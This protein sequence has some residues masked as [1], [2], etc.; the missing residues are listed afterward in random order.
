MNG[1]NNYWDSEGRIKPITIKT[2]AEDHGSYELPDKNIFNKRKVRGIAVRPPENRKRLTENG[3]NLVNEDVFYASFLSLRDS[4]STEILTKIPLE[5][6]VFDT[7]SKE[8]FYRIEPLQ[9]DVANSKVFCKNAS[10]LADDEEYEFYF[11]FE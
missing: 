10:A 1:A 11:L 6:L 9:I 7:N 8:R 5:F 2:C 3:K 4:V